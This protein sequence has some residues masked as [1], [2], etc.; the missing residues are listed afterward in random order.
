MNHPSPFDRLEPRTLFSFAEGGAIFDLLADTDRNGVIDVR[1]DAGED[2]W[3]SGKAG[4]GAVILPN[5]DRD[6]AGPAP[7]NWRGGVWLGRNIAPN[8][9]IDNAADLLDI[10]RF[11]LHKLGFEWQNYELELR[12]VRP[13][14][15]HASL[16]NVPANQRVRIF[17]PSKVSGADLV[18][19]ANDVAILGPGMD[20]TIRFVAEPAGPNELY[21]GLLDGDGSIEFG[22]E[23]LRLGAGVRLEVWARFYN[24]LFGDPNEPFTLRD[25]ITIRTAPFVMQTHEQ[26]I[27][28]GK[29]S[30]SAEVTSENAAFRAALRSVFGDRLIEVTSGGDPWH[31]DTHEIGY[32]RAPYGSMPVVLELPRAK[33]SF[34]GAT[35]SLVRGQ[36][37]RAGVGVSTELSAFPI[38]NASSYGGDIETLPRG[39]GKSPALLVSKTM[40]SYLKDFFGRQNVN[41]IVEVDPDGWLAV[42][43]VDEL[44]STGPDGKRL[45]TADPELAWALLQWAGKL[46][47][48]ASMLQGMGEFAYDPAH[49]NGTVKMLLDNAVLR[50]VNFD[51]VMKAENLPATREIVRAAL[52]LKE[53]VTR[54]AGDSTNLGQMRLTRAG[55][56]TQ[57]LGSV[58][59]TFEVKLGTGDT[60]TLRYRDAGQTNWSAWFAGSRSRDEVF[61]QARAFLLKHHWQG[62]RAVAGDTFRFNTNPDAT[63][64]RMPVLFTNTEVQLFPIDQSGNTSGIDLGLVRAMTSNFVNALANG[65]QVITSAA[66]GPKVNYRGD[67][68]RD[69]LEDYARA[70]FR[71]VGFSTV[72]FIDARS[73]HNGGGSVHCATNAIRTLPSGKW[74]ELV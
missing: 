16:A 10:G 49:P 17:M 20:S 54:P 5:I 64:I 57:L 39:A 11:R 4:R 37:L 13:S 59:R 42:G 68:P 61:P 65:G 2:R 22:I 8:S 74:W 47:I 1:D 28:S 46:N 26:A 40:P 45:A 50:K 18:P 30:V 69:I 44:F 21:S 12:L 67:G 34:T 66:Y 27:A 14:G 62:T 58:A 31:Q 3:T 51:R 9:V 56:F 63:M 60:Y 36:L 52:G 19:Q 23:G 43:H 73:Y 25:A 35:P 55:A 70:A 6:N 71:K 15:D 24:P 29:G 41:P 7:D 72:T 53:E 48:N 32:A 33:I 38:V